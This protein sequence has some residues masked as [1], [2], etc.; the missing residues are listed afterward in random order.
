M[1]NIEIIN[2]LKYRLQD[3]LTDKKVETDVDIYHY[4][5]E[6]KEGDN[7]EIQF[8]LVDGEK[9]YLLYNGRFPIVKEGKI[10]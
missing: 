9:K 8:V 6:E 7:Y 2:K 10:K 1:N 3:I 4:N 5:Y